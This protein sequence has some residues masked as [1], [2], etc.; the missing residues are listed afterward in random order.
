MND[1]IND[2]KNLLQEIEK[3]INEI[4]KQPSSDR[5]SKKDYLIVISVVFVCLLIIIL[6]AYL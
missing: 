6:S 3:R 2:N 1:N 4:E 5:F